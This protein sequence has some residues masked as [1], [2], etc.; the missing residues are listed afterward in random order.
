MLARADREVEGLQ[1]LDAHAAGLERAAR[2]LEADEGGAG[3]GHESFL[4]RTAPV[5]VAPPIASIQSR[6]TNAVIGASKFARS[7]GVA[8][9]KRRASAS[10][11]SNS[12]RSSFATTLTRDSSPPP[13]ASRGT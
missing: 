7:V 5:C 13:S 2:A 1:R 6:R 11:A 10:A 8:R 12:E 3:L 9:G 4:E